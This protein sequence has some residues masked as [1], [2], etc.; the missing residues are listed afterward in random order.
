MLKLRT[1]PGL[2]KYVEL[3]GLASFA[4]I[5]SSIWYNIVYTS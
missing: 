4:I 5:R 1:D 2:D 3:W